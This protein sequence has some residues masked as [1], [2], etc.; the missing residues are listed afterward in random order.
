MW[1]GQSG[2]K[3]RDGREAHERAPHLLWIYVG[4]YY[5]SVQAKCLFVGEKHLG[6]AVIEK[7]V[8]MSLDFK[9]RFWL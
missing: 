2:A 3:G 5:V 6:N 8:A 9:L 4:I 7:A 1:A